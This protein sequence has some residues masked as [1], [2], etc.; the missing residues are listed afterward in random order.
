MFSLINVFILK[1]IF[2]SRYSDAKEKAEQENQSE[3]S[4]FFT[5]FIPR[6][7]KAITAMF[8][9]QF[10]AVWNSYIYPLLYTTNVQSG[11]PML[12]ISNMLTS[13]VSNGISMNDP[14]LM[15]LALIVALPAVIAFLA[16]YRIINAEILSGRM[17]E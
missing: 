12:F 10:I 7:W 5:L 14:A 3:L 11:S 8:L 4:Q 13:A 2:N 1:S 17:R 9:I 16:G 6:T 15:K